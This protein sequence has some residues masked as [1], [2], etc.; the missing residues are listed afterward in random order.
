ME[1]EQSFIALIEQSIKTNWH[2]NA[3]TDYKGVT[4]QYRDVARKIEKIH[5]LLENAGI[6]KKDKIAI[7]GRNS[8]HWAVT[9]LA[10]I[11]YGATVVPIL[12]EFKADQ[13]HNIV[14]HS[15]ARL[16]FVD[17]QIWENLNEAAMPQLEGI[18]ELKD[19]GI[20]ISRSEHLTYARN[21]LNEIFGRKY[22]CRFRSDDIAYENEASEDL[23]IINYT[24]GTTGYSKG[25]MLPYRS[26]LSN[27]LNCKEKIGLKAGDRIVSMLPLGHVFGM[28]F[29]FLYGFISGAHLW[30]LTRMPSPKIIAESFA[31]IRPRVIACVPLIVEKIFKKNILPKVDSKLGKLLLHVPIVSDKIKELIKQKA[32]EV[33]GGNFIE[34]II[35]GAPFNAE[36]EAFLKMIDFPY[37]AAYGMTECGPTIC[38]SPWNELKLTSCGKIAANMEAKVLSPDPAV[39]PGELLCRGANLMLGYYKNQEATRQV[40]DDEGWLHTGDMATID[41]EGN[42]YIKGRCKNLLLTSSGQNIYPEEIESR[43]NNMPYVSESLVILQQDKLVALIYPDSDDAF[44]H[45]LNQSALEQVMEENRQELNKLLPAFSQITRFKLYLEEFEKTAKKS[46]KR[47]L[48]QDIKE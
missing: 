44:A 14:N 17:D 43:L 36:V 31:E 22:P 5:I 16:L 7:C 37:T 3:L 19:F 35:G 21:H 18:V 20:L 1:L 41:K 6:E 40:I 29:D 10:V 32:M 12:H 48:Y 47:F 45:G 46:I 34:I 26:I 28:T 15:E 23:A 38:H 9:F 39:I 24:S 11:T 4:L 42:I 13:V 33:F 27:V 25:V 2:L 8:A 30:F